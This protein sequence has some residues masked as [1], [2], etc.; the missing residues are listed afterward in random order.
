MP[1][2]RPI[3]SARTAPVM[4]TQR[5]ARRRS[6]VMRPLRLLVLALRL[7]GQTLRSA[8]NLPETGVDPDQESH[9]GEPRRRSGLRVDPPP[10]V[11]AHG[12]RQDELDTERAVPAVLFPRL[13]HGLVHDLAFT[14]AS[15]MSALYPIECGEA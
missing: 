10:Y 3:G 4:A 12:H 9:E 11:V 7:G 6:R 14:S 1:E 15:P 13:F 5:I 8:K 2:K